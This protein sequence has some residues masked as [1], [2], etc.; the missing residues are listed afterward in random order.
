MN[1][2]APFN[3]TL[4]IIYIS[5][6]TAIDIDS[7]S[8]IWTLFPSRFLPLIGFYAIGI[9]K[10]AVDYDSINRQMLPENRAALEALKNA[11]ISW[12]NER[13]LASLEHNDPTD[14]YS[15]PRSGAIDRE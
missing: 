11:M 8:A 13:Q 14:L 4:Y 3:G 1:G 12:D 7:A 9:F 6:S 15:Y 10:G 2:I 5:T